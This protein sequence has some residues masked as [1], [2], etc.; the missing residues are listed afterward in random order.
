MS[1]L[2]QIDSSI[3]DDNLTNKK[4]PLKTYQING[5]RISGYIDD[6]KAIIQ[7]VRKIIQTERTKYLIYDWD[8]GIELMDLYGKNPDYII[9]DL[10]TRFEEAFLQNPHIMA[11]KDFYCEL[12]DDESIAVQ[13][14][15]ETAYGEIKIEE[16]VL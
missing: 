4:Y 2:P 6:E 14:I 15:L 16:E 5:D 1:I 13:I 11:I 9:A 12:Q 8:Y 10:K 3:L 7:A